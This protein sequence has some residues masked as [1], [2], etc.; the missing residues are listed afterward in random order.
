MIG[1]EWADR[2]A[3]CADICH[4]WQISYASKHGNQETEKR[5]LVFLFSFFGACGACGPTVSP[6]RPWA[7]LGG[8]RPGTGGGDVGGLSV[9]P[10]TTAHDV[11]L[12]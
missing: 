11:S 4:V 6:V 12:Y 5:A 3:C 9:L 2:E 10:E 7:G 8:F 1:L